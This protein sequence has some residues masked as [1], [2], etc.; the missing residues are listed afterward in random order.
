MMKDTVNINFNGEDFEIKK[1]PMRRFPALGAALGNIPEV[2]ADVFMTD[3]GEAREVNTAVL[4]EKFPSVFMQ[5]SETVPVL[6][7]VISDI[8]L[9]KI[10][11]G[12]LD[13]FLVLLQ[14]V[15]EIN[16]IETIIKYLKNF[17]PTLQK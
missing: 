11:D 9:D 6:M 13:D 8:E 3:T 17:M 15:L 14:A 16:N 1:I 7:A 12:G 10:L 5:A 2:I 4:L